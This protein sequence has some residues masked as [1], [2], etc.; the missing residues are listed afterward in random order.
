M[1]PHAHPGRRRTA[2]ALV[3]ALTTGG[4]AAATALAP[5]AAAASSTV[6]ISQVYGGGGNTGAPYRNDYV[7]L[8]NRGSTAVDVSGWSVQYAS[9]A[10]TSYQRTDLTGSIAPG[11]R[12]LVAEGAGSGTTATPL[13]SP[14]VTG[15]I[16]MSGSNGKVALVSTQTSLA[17]GST[18]A[19]SAGVVDFVGYGS[20][21]DAE[22][23]PTPA[24]SNTTAA[25]RTAAPDTDDNAA[26]FTVGAPA[27]AGAVVT[28]PP[29][30]VDCTA[31]PTD[32]ACVAGATT[33]EDVQGDGFV[34]PLDGTTVTKVPGVVT[35]VR[36]SGSGRGY[37]LQ[38]TDG[39]DPSASD[40]VQVF[41]GAA[42]PGVAVGDAVLVSGTVTEYR[43]GGAANLSVT[44]I[45]SPTTTRLSS[46]NPLPAPL[47]LTPTT[48]PT[49]YAATPVTGS[50]VE[51]I[52]TVDP[53]RSAQEFYEAHEGEVVSVTDARVVGA[54]TA[55]G[56]LYVTSKPD[57]QATPRGGTYLPSYAAL[58]TGRIKV[59]SLVPSATAAFPVVDVGDRLTGTTAGPL[60]HDQ[61]GGYGIQATTIGAVQDGGLTREV[62]TAQAADQ[63]AVATYNVE[64]LSPADPQA[65]FDRLAEGIVSN[66]ASPDVVTLEE[67]Q[68]D[69]GPTDDGVVGATQT[70]AQLAAA[71]TAAGG[72]AYSSTEID[73]VDGRD[74]GQPGG[75]IRN[76]FLWNPDRVTFVDKAAPAG[77][78][79]ST[80]PV[81]VETGTDGRAHLTFS[82]G[83]VDPDNAAWAS[84]RKPLA[85]E[86]TFRGEPVIVIGN[87]FNS[88]GG[89]QPAE[90]VTQPPV[91][92]SEVQ[93]TQQ[94]QVLG[95]FVDQVVAAG[96]DPNLVLAGDFNDY[97]FSA[98]VTTL[99]QDGARLTDLITT[100]PAAEQYTYVFNGVSQVLD[101][102]L[103]NPGLA[104]RRADAVEYDV[105]HVN[106]EFADQA[107]D[108]EPQVVRLRLGTPAAATPAVTVDPADVRAG[109]A[110]AVALSG[111]APGATVTLRLDGTRELATVVVDAQGSGSASVVVPPVTREGAHTV[112]A[113]AGGQSASAALTVIPTP[114][115][116]R[117][118]AL[119]RAFVLRFFTR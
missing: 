117:F 84:S 91:R 71:I 59:E 105:V 70:L 11:A 110:A 80:T 58:P 77:T 76:A 73:P 18:C 99:T 25:I 106:S 90:G 10:G 94:A 23:A 9:S 64:N 86:F 54:T 107:S 53:T 15:T 101:H 60:D 24:L 17:C 7:E 39:A 16:A 103:V 47:A 1:T 65:K 40:G 96:T 34:S 113:T 97:Q 29:A 43:P 22:T 67:I 8:T 37:W 31:T 92:S 3:L 5:T 75:N 33:V 82:P 44:E 89:D 36:D 55:Y 88:K 56:E 52:T 116:E 104:Q 102:I 83:R 12:Y 28:P 49:P 95:A 93:R 61:F 21:N 32:P 4:L 81:G 46:G 45:T 13:P 30:P 35:A 98:P 66:L 6:V 63:L 72:P 27:P 112:V 51:T 2:A 109:S 38:Q 87:H 14:A 78:D 114:L 68:D 119:L 69:T 42:S 108:H 26:D 85:G 41:T 100:L 62:T 20:A 111:F 57:E 74:G 19:G 48:V 79:L 118:A 115:L 50:S